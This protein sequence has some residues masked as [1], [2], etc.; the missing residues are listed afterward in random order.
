M[1]KT[2][3]TSLSLF[4]ITAILL[5]TIGNTNASRLYEIDL[6]RQDPNF[7]IDPRWFSTAVIAEAKANIKKEPEKKAQFL[8]DIASAKAQQGK[9]LEALE[10]MA[11]IED[12][13]V[14]HNA[15]FLEERAEIKSLLGFDISAIED[16]DKIDTKYRNWKTLWHRSIVL[17]RAGKS[18]EGLLD[19]RKAV[20]E[21]ERFKIGDNY[22]EILLKT[23]KQ[24]QITA[25]KPE[26]EMMA[27]TLEI[28]QSLLHY[29]SAPPL[30][31]TIKLIGLEGGQVEDSGTGEQLYYASNKSPI[32]CASITP[33]G[34]QIRISFD[35]A[36][37]AI[38]PEIVRKDFDAG[39]EQEIWPGAMGGCGNG[40]LTLYPRHQENVICQFIFDGAKEPALREFFISYKEKSAT[41]GKA[42]R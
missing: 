21:A 6:L 28:I 11:L 41:S 35:A 27:Q 1:Q 30:A 39:T 29:H 3:K 7:P 23:A 38:S 25:L 14:K 32:K 4:F 8:F 15:D 22:V 37:S 10:Q 19:F 34:Q 24:H 12:D 36:A 2:Q 33:T 9:L 17:Q 40:T 18:E 31:E 5:L 13:N 16:M 20:A 42:T 26:P